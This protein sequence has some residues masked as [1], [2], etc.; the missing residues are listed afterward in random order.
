MRTD[1]Y[2]VHANSK[3][4]EQRATK[5]WTIDEDKRFL[6][7]VGHMHSGA[8]NVS[9]F[10]NEKFVCASYPVYGKTPG[11]AGDELGHLVQ[12]TRCVDDGSAK[13]YPDHPSGSYRD[14]PIVV[15]AGDELRVDGWYYVG[16]HDAR[17]L[18]TPAGAHLGVMS[19]FYAV[20][21][22]GTAGLP[23]TAPQQ[24]STAERVLLGLGGVAVVCAAAVGFARVRKKR[25]R[26][27]GGGQEGDAQAPLLAAQAAAPGEAATVP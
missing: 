16:D 10:V 15:K 27:A 18:P 24:T 2:N 14:Q 25:R 5:T 12:A 7:G 3:H 11:K 19:Y 4:P 20:F 1:E 26:A 17:I 8:L 13:G 9:V 21:A 6:F 23:P 22:K